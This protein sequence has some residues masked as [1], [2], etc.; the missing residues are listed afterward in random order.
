MF[1]VPVE[2][3]VKA[4]CVHVLRAIVV[5]EGFHPAPDHHAYL[6]ELEGT[7]I[8]TPYPG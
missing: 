7:L 4:I 5:L 2:F 6:L 1:N 3:N 8:L